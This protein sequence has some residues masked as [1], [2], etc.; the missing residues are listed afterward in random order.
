MAFAVS[1]IGSR[2]L[3][4]EEKRQR[5]FKL[6]A[7]IVRCGGQVHSGNSQIYLKDGSRPKVPLN[8]ADFA[9]ASGGNSVDPTQ[10]YLYQPWNGF[11]GYQIVPGNHVMLPPYPQWMEDLVVRLHDRGPY[12]KRGPLGLHTRNVAIVQPT[13]LCLAYP[14]QKLGGGGTGMGIRVAQHLGIEFIDLNHY[15]TVE[16]RALC[17]RI[18]TG[19][20]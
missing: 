4:T 5:C 3:G 16:L 20:R 15:G 14:S 10:V 8:S 7:W 9:F 19:L 17:E 6:G 12:L 13:Q 2:E 11:N 18:R 1:C